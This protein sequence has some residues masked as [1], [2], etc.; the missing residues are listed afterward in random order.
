MSKC[1]ANVN[2]DLEM[3]QK[4]PAVVCFGVPSRHAAGG[5]EQN[6]MRMY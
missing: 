5:T 3:L 6:K 1:R 4:G 2:V